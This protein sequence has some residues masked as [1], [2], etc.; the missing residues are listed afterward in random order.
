VA[1]TIRG[2]S[3]I[4]S[5]SFLADITGCNAA[6]SSSLQ[7]LQKKENINICFIDY[8]ID[9]G[10]KKQMGCTHAGCFIGVCTFARSVSGT[11]MQRVASQLNDV[12][13]PV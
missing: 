8:R 3:S 11:P 7:A 6:Y 12:M 4:S 9:S 2:K 10:L 1:K 5:G 13:L